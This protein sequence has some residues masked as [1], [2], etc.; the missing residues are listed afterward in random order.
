MPEN[1]PPTPAIQ[2]IF[3]KSGRLNRCKKALPRHLHQFYPAPSNRTPTD[4]KG[5]AKLKPTD[6]AVLDVG[7]TFMQQNPNSIT[8]DTDVAGLIKDIA[9]A[10][11]EIIVDAEMQQKA[12]ITRVSL[13]AVLSDGFKTVN[14][15]YRVEKAK[16]RNPQ[17]AAFLDAYGARF[18]HGP[19]TPPATPPPNP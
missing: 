7:L 13:I 11:Q 3:R 10:K 14:E 16:G 6:V 19:Q 9:L 4:I 8:G 15:V 2:A 5:L 18:A 1:N 17:N 12:N